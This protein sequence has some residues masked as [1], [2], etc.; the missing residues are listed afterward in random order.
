MNRES[1][2][3]LKR[4]NHQIR[5]NKDVE[6]SQVGILVKV[7]TAIV[8]FLFFIA[9]WLSIE[10]VV[11]MNGEVPEDKQMRSHKNEPVHD[12]LGLLLASNLCFA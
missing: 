3:K 5:N 1:V 8:L 9:F 7:F 12:K 10:F 4:G 2:S 11:A 6:Y